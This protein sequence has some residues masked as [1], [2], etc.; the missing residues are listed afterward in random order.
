MARSV[1]PAALPDDGQA[2]RSAVNAAA[3]RWLLLGYLAGSRQTP[4]QLSERLGIPKQRMS[5]L[6]LNRR[7]PP[8]GDLLVLLAEFGVSPAEVLTAPPGQPAERVA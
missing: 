3:L 4:Q 1:P 5:D 8:P 6:R 7:V 2:L